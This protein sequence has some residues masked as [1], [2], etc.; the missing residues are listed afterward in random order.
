MDKPNFSRRDFL[1]AGSVLGASAVVPSV[2]Y[3]SGIISTEKQGVCL[4]CWISGN[5]KAGYASYDENAS[6]TITGNRIE[7]NAV[8]FT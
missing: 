8:L 2:T 1:S 7:W 3:N 4:M 6:N 5:G